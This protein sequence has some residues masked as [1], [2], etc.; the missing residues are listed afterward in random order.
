MKIHMT[1]EQLDELIVQHNQLLYKINHTHAI[2]SLAGY[3]GTVLCGG[4]NILAWK[5]KMNEMKAE[6]I[7]IEALIPNI[8]KLGGG[9]FFQEDSE[10]MVKVLNCPKCTHLHSDHDGDGICSECTVYGGKCQMFKSTKETK[11]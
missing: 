4:L 9:K 10:A 7:R 1:Q 2:N 6:L 5:R 8:E 11:K 3:I